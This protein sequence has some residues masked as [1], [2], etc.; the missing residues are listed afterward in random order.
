VLV[1]R[2]RRATGPLQVLFATDGSEASRQAGTALARATW[3][4]GTQGFV[5]TVLEPYFHSLPNWLA[6]TTRDPSIDAL[7]QGWMQE[8]EA[9]KKNKRAEMV[10]LAHTLPAPFQANEPIIA[11]GHPAELILKAIDERKIDLVVVGAQGKSAWEQFMIGSTSERL[12]TAAP[13]SV[14]IVRK[15]GN[16]TDVAS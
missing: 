5:M 2:P 12:L 7:T 6:Q 4:A 15:R 16:N 10:A 3:P 14:L 8:Y 1:T 13:C 11:E 9:D